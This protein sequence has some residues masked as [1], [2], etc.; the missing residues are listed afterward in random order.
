MSDVDLANHDELLS[1]GVD[2]VPEPKLYPSGTW[3]LKALSGTVKPKDDDEN[4]KQVTI[5]VIGTEP[6][7]DVDSDELDDADGLYEGTRIFVRRNIENGNDE[8]QLAKLLKA[9]GFTNDDGPMFECVKNIKG[10]EA[11]AT[12]GMRSYKNRNGEQVFENTARNFIP[13]E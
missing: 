9:F 4:V 7:E 5:T 10:R 3:R 12:L 6:G 1:R 13:V 11:F 8:Y 2:A